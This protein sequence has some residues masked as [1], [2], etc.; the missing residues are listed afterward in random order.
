MGAFDRR[1][2]IVEFGYCHFVSRWRE[3]NGNQGSA[4]PVFA[5]PPQV[6]IPWNH[7]RLRPDV[8]MAHGN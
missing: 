4:R 2:L 6:T 5:Q 1:Q 8:D 3:C 7:L